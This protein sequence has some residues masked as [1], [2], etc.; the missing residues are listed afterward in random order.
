MNIIHKETTE[1]GTVVVTEPALRKLVDSVIENHKGRVYLT[2]SRGKRMNKVYKS[3]RGDQASD[4]QV[5]VHNGKVSICVYIII[6]FGMSISETTDKLIEELRLAYNHVTG[7]N[8]WKIKIVI[9]GV[10]SKK[11]AKR[12]IE[13]EKT[14]D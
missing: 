8:P 3:V 12:N 7:K 1:Y 6:K 5:F 14:Y 11:L 10:M 9:T 4:V 13:V 2:N